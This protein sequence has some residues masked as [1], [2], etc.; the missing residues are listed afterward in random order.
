MQNSVG[1]N[2]C[3]NISFGT[4]TLQTV[5]SSVRE[6]R[7][8]FF[9][10]LLPTGRAAFFFILLSIPWKYHGSRC[11]PGKAK[12]WE[13]FREETPS[14]GEPVRHSGGGGGGA[15]GGRKNRVTYA[16]KLLELVRFFNPRFRFSFIF[17]SISNLR[18][19]GE[20]SVTIRSRSECLN[21]A[22]YRSTVELETGKRRLRDAAN[23]FENSVHAIGEGELWKWC[24]LREKRTPNTF[25]RETI[26]LIVLMDAILHNLLTLRW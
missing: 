14:A 2:T 10:F 8:D 21:E 12:K 26:E 5:R 19:P 4:C 6:K 16:I 13:E 3:S 11:S 20:I 9:S 15:K 18:R 7:R 24:F 22:Q 25:E 17:T 23:L 1:D